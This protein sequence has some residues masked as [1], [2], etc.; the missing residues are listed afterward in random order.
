VPLTNEVAMRVHLF[1]DPMLLERRASLRV[2]LTET[3]DA[4]RAQG[5]GLGIEAALAG[6]SNESSCGCEVLHVFGAG[7]RNEAVLA[8]ARAQGV[9]VLLSP[10]LAPGWSRANGSRARVGDRV[11]GN[12][13]ACDLDSGYAQ[14]R[15]AL[16]AADLLVAQDEA[17]RKAICEAFLVAPEKVG[18]VAHGVAAR[19]FEAR[20]GLFR[21]RVHIAGRFAL[22]VGQVCPY[23]NQLGVA[24]ALAELALPLVV[25]GGTRER[26]VAYLRE[27]RALRTVTCVGPLPHGDPLLA[28]A[29]AAASVCVFARPVGSMPMAMAEALAAGTPVVAPA[30]AAPCALVAGGAL[31][32]AG[33]DDPCALQRAVS[34]LLEQPAQRE[35]VRAL[36]RRFTWP[37]A[38]RQLAHCYRALRA[39]GR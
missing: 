17:E 30:G 6:A 2:Q 20:P 15:R 31:R 21:E 11:L 38:A 24:R 33:G 32:H 16:G 9:P 12:R 29:Y 7:G 37:G 8:A 5:A 3:L 36:V 22:M 14:I 19:F 27:L 10:R 34:D 28:S 4:L 39:A 23:A 35:A 1:A 26:D 25:V 18:V 13:S